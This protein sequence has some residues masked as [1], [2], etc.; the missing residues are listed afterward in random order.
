MKYFNKCVLIVLILVMSFLCVPV[1]AEEVSPVL[2]TLFDGTAKSGETVT[3]R[4]YLSNNCGITSLRV[5]ISFDDSQLTLTKVSDMGILGEYTFKDTLESPYVLYWANDTSA[6][7]TQNGVLAELTFKIADNAEKGAQFPVTVTAESENY[8]I[9]NNKLQAVETLCDGAVITAEKTVAGLDPDFYYSVNGNEMTVTGNKPNKNE[10][11]IENG[12][13]V[14]GGE[15]TVTAIADGAF[16]GNTALAAAV[17]PNSVTAIGNGAFAGCSALEKLS[18]PDNLT[19][20]GVASF[21]NCR[22]L[23]LYCYPKTKTEALI[24][25]SGLSYK[26]YGDLIEDK[27]INSLDLT[28]MRRLLLGTAS[29]DADIADLTRNG[30]ADIL[31]LIRLKKLCG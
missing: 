26:L 3:L 28:A 25:Q 24:S 30:E 1:H 11:V 31:D 4:L 15:Y 12:Y 16:F 29:Y 7:Y 17:L 23:S 6:D 27:K 14:N 13:S 9:L 20:I 8:D 5:R 2:L 10:I 18:L 19:F 21:D 22:Q